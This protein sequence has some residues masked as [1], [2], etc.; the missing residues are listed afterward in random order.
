MEKEQ[1]EESPDF[2]LMKYELDRQHELEL[3]KFAHALEVERLKILQLVNGGA[4]TVVVGFS[5]HLLTSVGQVRQLGLAA[6]A[7]WAL[8]LGAAA[9]ATQVQLK[10]QGGFNQAYRYRRTAVEW[11]RLMARLNN[12]ERVV[13]MVGAP[14]A[15]ETAESSRC[16]DRW[17]K[18]AFAK[19]VAKAG[20]VKFWAWASILLFIAGA[21]LLTASI[22]LAD[23]LP[24]EAGKAS[25]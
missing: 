16:Y 21:S 4:F 12:K 2:E 15:G 1:K 10:A 24:A 18:E 13:L 25:R 22:S 11:R 20:K 6:G 9:M 3:N 17:A 8:G 7:C 14:P 19:A 23:P 5:T